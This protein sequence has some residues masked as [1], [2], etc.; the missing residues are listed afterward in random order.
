[1]L[2]QVLQDDI[3]ISYD[4]LCDIDAI[5]EYIDIWCNQVGTEN[6]TE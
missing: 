6:I 4:S 3:F 2:H 1:M 5:V